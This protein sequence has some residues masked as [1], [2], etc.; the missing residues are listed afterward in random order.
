M[1]EVVVIEDDMYVVNAIKENRLNSN[2]TYGN[3]TGKILQ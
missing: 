1:L 2:I 3:D